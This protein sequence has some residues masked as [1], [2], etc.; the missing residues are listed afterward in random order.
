MVR[1]FIIENG[2]SLR[3]VRSWRKKTGPALVALMVT[4]T[5]AKKGA[6]TRRMT[7]DARMSNDRFRN[8]DPR[9]NEDGAMS[10]IGSPDRSSTWERLVI[11]S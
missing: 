4:A 7:D 8:R 5:A 6:A 10:S 2:C 9:L 3:P 11:S 1:N